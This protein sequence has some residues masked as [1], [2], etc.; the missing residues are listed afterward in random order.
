M[1]TPPHVRTK[2]PFYQFRAIA[3][4]TKFTISVHI[5][6][7]NDNWLILIEAKDRCDSNRRNL[8]NLINEASTN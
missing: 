3:D 7:F 8:I 6:S 4:S 5:E 1:M 2:I